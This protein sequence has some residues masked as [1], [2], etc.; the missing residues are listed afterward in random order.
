M[1]AVKQLHRRIDANENFVPALS[2]NR[3]WEYFVKKF[4][5][6]DPERGV[7]DLDDY[8]VVLLEIDGDPFLL[9]RYAG[10]PT[11]M[12]DVFIPSSLATSSRFLDRIVH[13]LDVPR[14]AI[15]PHV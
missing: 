5:L 12:I 3:P 9:F 13:E 7:D 14:E 8:E 6:S 1:S 15:T 10:Y 2:L 11:N 4:H